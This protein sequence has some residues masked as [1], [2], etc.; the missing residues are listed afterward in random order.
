MKAFEH[1]ESLDLVGIPE[2]PTARSIQKGFDSISS[3]LAVMAG[4]KTTVR[5][6]RANMDSG[7]L[8][9]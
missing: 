8:K 6:T 1:L 5:K 3:L 2:L 9:K 7:I 4:K